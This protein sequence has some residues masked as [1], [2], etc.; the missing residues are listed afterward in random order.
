MSHSIKHYREMGRVVAHDKDLDIKS[1]YDQ[2][3]ELYM[4]ALSLKGTVKKC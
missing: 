2:C 4:Q 1:L 3:E